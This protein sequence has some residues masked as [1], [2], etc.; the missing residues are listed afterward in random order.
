MIT[1]ELFCAFV[2]QAWNELAASRVGNHLPSGG[3]DT[4]QM[5]R[6]QQL[7]R[8]CSIPFISGRAALPASSGSPLDYP[9]LLMAYYNANRNALLRYHCDVPFLQPRATYS[10]H[11][12]ASPAFVGQPHIWRQRRNTRSHALTASHRNPSAYTY[13]RQE[14]EAPS[15]PT[16]ANYQAGRY[17]ELRGPTVMPNTAAEPSQNS[18][19]AFTEDDDML[20]EGGRPSWSPR[21]LRYH[22]TS[23]G[24]SASGPRESSGIPV[25]A[26]NYGGFSDEEEEVEEDELQGRPTVRL[27]PPRTG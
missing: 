17:T 1:E 25:D 14:G 26:L 4:A 11:Q 10:L 18:W 7:P 6:Q 16:D 27:G 9:D 23:G 2:H 22:H 3:S 21:Q 20:P 5:Q 24:S 12:R 8:R 15:P 19:G 13:E